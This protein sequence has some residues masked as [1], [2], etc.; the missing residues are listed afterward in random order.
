MM[1]VRPRRLGDQVAWRIAWRRHIIYI[2]RHEPRWTT[3]W[4]LRKTGDEL[5]DEEFG[6]EPP[7]L[8]GKRQAIMPAPGALV[9]LEA[10]KPQDE[11]SRM[12]R[13]LRK[14]RRNAKDG[15]R[16]NGQRWRQSKLRYRLNLFAE[17]IQWDHGIWALSPKIR[18]DAD[19]HKSGLWPLLNFRWTFTPFFENYRGDNFG[20]WFGVWD[21]LRKLVTGLA[22]GLIIDDQDPTRDWCAL[23]A[24]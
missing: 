13:A 20:R 4:Q 15:A 5:D 6:Y 16:E 19:E 8:D 10:E 22:I 23:G 11:W 12:A 21:L 17:W 18:V 9:A 2:A 1:I 3:Y 14:M 7:E 24:I